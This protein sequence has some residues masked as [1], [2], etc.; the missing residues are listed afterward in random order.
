M[1]PPLLLV[2]LACCGG[3]RSAI[4]PVSAPHHPMAQAVEWSPPE[5]AP[6]PVECPREGVCDAQ[7]LLFPHPLDDYLAET[8]RLCLDR[9]AWMASEIVRQ[10]DVHDAELV[11]CYQLDERM[12]WYVHAAWGAAMGAVTGMVI[13]VGLVP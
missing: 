5:D 12:P 1:R 3:P 10:Q 13:A 8:T 11:A 2:L 9:S 6:E 4:V 7:G